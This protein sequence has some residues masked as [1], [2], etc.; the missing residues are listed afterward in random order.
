MTVCYFTTI[1]VITAG[2]G[3]LEVEQEEHCNKFWKTMQDRINLDL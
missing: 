2:V 1:T 3:G